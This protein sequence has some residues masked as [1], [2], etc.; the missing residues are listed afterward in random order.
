MLIKNYI[1]N[2]MKLTTEI[3]KCSNKYYFHKWIE[4][5][6]IQLINLI[7]KYPWISELHNVFTLC[8]IKAEEIGYF[9]VSK[10]I[11]FSKIYKYL[12]RKLKLICSLKNQKLN[13]NVR[14]LIKPM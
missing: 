4:I 1:S 10:R 14:N 9:G 11:K 7:K 13:I 3:I 6:L 8:L 12:L 2:L 5:F